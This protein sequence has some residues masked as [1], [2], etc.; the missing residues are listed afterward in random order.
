[1]Q[2]LID[3]LRRAE[4]EIS[5]AAGSIRDVAAVRE[6]PSASEA[7]RVMRQLLEEIDEQ[8]R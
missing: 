3:D 4:I 8:L 7:E 1:M 6:L 5:D 2:N